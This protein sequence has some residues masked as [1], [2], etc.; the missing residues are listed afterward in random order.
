MIDT[1]KYKA[2]SQDEMDQ[3]LVEFYRATERDLFC[4]EV[5]L[6]RYQEMLKTIPEGLWRERITQLAVETEA[7]I[8]EVQSVLEA[9]K[10]KQL[11]PE[12]RFKAAL[13]VVQGKERPDAA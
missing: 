12:A 3:I 7:R 4:H 2:L 1:S 11:P 6:E 13:E 10:L 8:A 5:N 9:T